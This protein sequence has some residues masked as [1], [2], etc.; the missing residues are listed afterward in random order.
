MATSVR[1]FAEQAVKVEQAAR[2]SGIPRN[3]GRVVFV[4]SMADRRWGISQKEVVERT[5]LPKD[6]V[7]KL[8]DSL[9]KAGLL[10]ERRDSSNPRVKKL[11]ATRSGRNLLSRVQDALQPP[12]PA[13]KPPVA[14]LASEFEE[15]E[16]PCLAGQDAGSERGACD[17]VE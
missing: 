4:L 9:V 2:Q 7:S 3:A 5:A 14:A 15:L 1:K 17:R 6:V 13:P 11:L 8:V 12:P 16:E 10:T